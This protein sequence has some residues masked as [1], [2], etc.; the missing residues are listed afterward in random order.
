MAKKTTKEEDKLKQ[1][2]KQIT[3]RMEEKLKKTSTKNKEESAEPTKKTGSKKSAEPK[4]EETPKTA[5]PT[6]KTIKYET[7]NTDTK[8]IPVQ[9][10]KIDKPANEKQRQYKNKFSIK[11]GVVYSKKNDTL[12]IAFEEVKH[13]NEKGTN[14]INKK[15]LLTQ[16]ER[17]D[18]YF[19]N[20][21][22]YIE[23]IVISDLRILKGSRVMVG[24]SGGVDSVV[25]L[26]VFVNLAEKFDFTVIVSHFN[27]QLRGKE[28]IKDEE[29]VR[30]ICK[31][32]NVQF[33]HSTRN[34]ENFAKENG[35]SIEDAAR[36]LRYEFFKNASEKNNVNY[37]LTAHTVDDNVETFLLNLF[38]GS[39]L[40]GLAAI[41]HKRDLSNNVVL[42]RPFLGLTKDEI[43]EYA[44][45]RKLD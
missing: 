39:G 41:P 37:F 4:I 22:S 32:Y 34:V 35:Y 1:L 38:R 11:S 25:L 29:F 19:Y 14:S 42:A 40:T 28:S 16:A 44:K 9:K 8:V 5:E 24:V 27:H 7:E 3:Q 45:K 26:D 17:K 10:Q 13:Y 33:Y 36:R 6:K 12:D 2:S 30:D 18:S 21:Y 23:S 43:I 31:N 20:F 15:V